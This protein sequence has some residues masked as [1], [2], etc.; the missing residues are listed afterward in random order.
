LIFQPQNL[1]ARALIKHAKEESSLHQGPTGYGAVM[2]KVRRFYSPTLNSAY[3]FFTE[4]QLEWPMP[5]KIKA[6]PLIKSEIK[7][8]PPPTVTSATVRRY[9]SGALISVPTSAAKRSGTTATH[10]ARAR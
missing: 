5:Q 10:R 7:D 3:I 2:A 8:E 9:K 1:T 4:S 6:E